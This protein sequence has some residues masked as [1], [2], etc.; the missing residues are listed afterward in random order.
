MQG[1]QG[2]FKNLLKSKI[3][4]S[5]IAKVQAVCLSDQTPRMTVGLLIKPGSNWEVYV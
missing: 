5:K 3:D 4:I 1:A 2:S